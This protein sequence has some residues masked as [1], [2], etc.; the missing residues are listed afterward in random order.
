MVIAVADHPFVERMGPTDRPALLGELLTN[1]ASFYAL[2]D[3][4][5]SGQVSVG[6][7]GAGGRTLPLG[8]SRVEFAAGLL[9]PGQLTP[10]PS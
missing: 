7:L 10:F 1:L 5:G 9:V 6:P 4:V 3:A 8:S 2:G